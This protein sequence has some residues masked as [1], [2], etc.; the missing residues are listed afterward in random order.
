MAPVSFFSDP[1]AGQLYVRENPTREQSLVEAGQCTEE[2]L[3]CTVQISASKRVP[4]ESKAKPAVFLAAT[5]NGSEAFFAGAGKLTNDATTG[6]GDAGNDLYR[7]DLDG[8]TLV[9]L[10][11][12]TESGDPQ[13]RRS[14]GRTGNERRRLLRLSLPMGCSLTR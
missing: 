12:D 9:D 1:G 6:P 10:T 13:W 3:A 5:P 4:P 11:P 7:Y 14:T 2:A 8:E